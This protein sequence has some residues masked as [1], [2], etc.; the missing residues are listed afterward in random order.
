[1]SE[2]VVAKRYADALFQLGTEKQAHEEMVEEFRV[3]KEIFQDNKR[4]YTFLK[5]PRVNNE[6]KKQ[7]LDE[8]FQGMST[9]VVNTLKLLV[10]RH[11]V[12]IIPFVIDQ[13]RQM[14]YDAQGIAEA[15]VY[16]VQ[17]LSDAE[18]KE[19]AA[20][21]AKRLGKKEIKLENKIDPSIIGGVKLQIGNTIYDGS[22]HAKLKRIERNIAGAN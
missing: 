7:F 2:A 14:V 22:L 21:F 9:D 16:S 12:E 1:M 8:V 5:H 15:T 3:V 20:V 17:E 4:L 18:I 13:F 11:R 19:L 6:K 10:E